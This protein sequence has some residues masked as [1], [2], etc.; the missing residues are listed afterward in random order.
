M[1][2][3]LS[4]C[5][6][7]CDIRWQPYCYFVVFPEPGELLFKYSAWQICYQSVLILSY[8]ITDITSLNLLFSFLYTWVALKKMSICIFWWALWNCM[9]KQL[10]I[11][12]RSNCDK[13]WLLVLSTNHSEA[14]TFLFIW[15]S[16]R[17]H[18]FCI[19]TRN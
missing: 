11:Q 7:N 10:R 15:L 3:I 5:L 17:G 14:G 13:H 12:S 19:D 6:F 18:S 16:V 8:R 2:T 1:F 4:A 9:Q